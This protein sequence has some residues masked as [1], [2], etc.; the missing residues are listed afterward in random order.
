MPNA[1]C[2]EDWKAF[3]K[4]ACGTRSG[5]TDEAACLKYQR[6]R[7]AS[8]G[9]AGD[10]ALKPAMHMACRPLAVRAARRPTSRR[11]DQREG[12]SRDLLANK[13]EALE[14]GKERSQM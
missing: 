3:S 2:D 8:T 1:G 7:P 10:P 14:I 4:G 9:Q 12:I 11:D 5:P 6:D 13:P